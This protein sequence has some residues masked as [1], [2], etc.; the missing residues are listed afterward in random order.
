MMARFKCSLD[1]SSPHQ[2]K[3]SE[4]DSGS[5]HEMCFVDC[6]VCLMKTLYFKRI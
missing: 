4:L 3:L 1:P 6:S 5:V 2:K